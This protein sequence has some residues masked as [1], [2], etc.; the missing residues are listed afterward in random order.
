[1]TRLTN[2]DFI[3]WNWYILKHQNHEMVDETDD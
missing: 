2:T 3:R 1:M